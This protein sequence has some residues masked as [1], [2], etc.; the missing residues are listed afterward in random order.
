MDV[1][2]HFNFKE[3]HCIS[4]STITFACS[5]KLPWPVPDDVCSYHGKLHSKPAW[6]S[7]GCAW[8]IFVV[9]IDLRMTFF[10]SGGNLNAADKD[11]FDLLNETETRDRAGIPSKQTGSLS[12][13]CDDC[14]VLAV[15]CCPGLGCQP[16]ST[17][18]HTTLPVSHSSAAWQG[19]WGLGQ[20]TGI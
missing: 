9:G 6:E 2:Q 18:S 14:S 4:I 5:I 12:M 20:K 17:L 1:K 15:C 7:P 19:W 16:N 10:K 11:T 3:F 13:R 8:L